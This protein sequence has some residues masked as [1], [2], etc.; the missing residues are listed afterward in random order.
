MPTS[1]V[2]SAG[3]MSDLTLER[4]RLVPYSPEDVTINQD[5]YLT[6]S[7]NPKVTNYGD[8]LNLINLSFR[9]LSKDNYDGTVNGLKTWFED[10][11]INWM[12]NNFTLTDEN[13][14]AHTVR[15]WN[16]KWRMSADRGGRYS[17]TLRLLKE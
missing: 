7:N 9:H 1:I 12:V 4:G 11:N 15:L 14:Q 3:G 10:A 2:F 6:E 5:N 16:K 13:G 17:I 8:N